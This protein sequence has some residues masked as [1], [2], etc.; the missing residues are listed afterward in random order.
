ME[1]RIRLENVGTSDA[2]IRGRS[3]GICAENEAEKKANL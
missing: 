1:V 3:C 2:W